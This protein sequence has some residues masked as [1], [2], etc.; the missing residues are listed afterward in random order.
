[1]KTRNISTLAIIAGT[2]VFAIAQTN[3]TLT[4]LEANEI[5]VMAEALANPGANGVVFDETYQ[6]F[7]VRDAA[8]WS[9]S[10]RYYLSAPLYVFDSNGGTPATLTIDAGTIVCNTGDGAEP[11]SGQ[12]GAIVVSR[13]GQIF[14]DGT[15]DQPIYFTTSNYFEAIRGVDI[16]GNGTVAEFP[17]LETRGTWGGIILLGDSFVANFSTEF[18]VGGAVLPKPILINAIEGF[19]APDTN[20]NDL[21]NDGLND[22]ITYGTTGIPNVAHSS[23]SL[24]YV[25]ISHGGV[26]L[27]DGNEINGLTL[28]GV[29]SG[30]N[31]FAIEVL[32]N[33][34]DG[35]EFFGGTANLLGGFVAYQ[36]DDGLDIDEGYNGNIQFFVNIQSDSDQGGEWD[37]NS[38][39]DE[40]NAVSRPIIANFTL[41]GDNE[42]DHAMRFDDFFAGFLGNGVITN[43][44]DLVDITGDYFAATRTQAFDNIYHDVTDT[45]V[46]DAGAAAEN[47]FLSEL[48]SVPDV[49]LGSITFPF[50]PTPAA[51]SVVLGSNGALVYDLPAIT[52][53]PFFL[54]TD[55]NGAFPEG[56]NWLEGWTVA[57]FVFGMFG[58]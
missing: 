14:A 44:A 23:G 55:F 56:F 42:G 41:I 27:G 43:F 45:D 11:G 7:L 49:G 21:D 16:D 50:D 4:N 58:E 36:G 33:E 1:M 9:A 37:G 13:N 6:Q 19:P 30:T 15:E 53:N 29:G 24:S 48:V 52:G 35:I 22:L 2:T 51:N 34:D 8:Q 38:S 57:D 3:T 54:S 46:S 32:S 20:I 5:D 28:G 10:N 39:G 40:T 26:N 47:L 12:Y 18:E 17:T 31:L 25:S